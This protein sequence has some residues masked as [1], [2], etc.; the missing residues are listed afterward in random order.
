MLVKTNTTQGHRQRCMC[1]ML[2][3]LKADVENFSHSRVA[4]NKAANTTYIA[5]FMRCLILVRDA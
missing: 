3:I 4:Q 5:T 1:A 2:A